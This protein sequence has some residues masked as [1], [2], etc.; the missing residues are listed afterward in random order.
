NRWVE[1]T[2]ADS[3]RGGDHHREREPVR[4]R[5]ADQP[6]AARTRDCDRAHT[7][8]HQR[9]RPNELSNQRLGH[10]ARPPRHDHRAVHECPALVRKGN[11][12]QAVSL[13]LCG[14]PWESHRQAA[15]RMAGHTTWWRWPPW[16]G[17]T[18][19]CWR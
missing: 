15:A 4:Q 11:T 10:A 16:C 12:D 3:G 5:H 9:E 7:H 13:I 6:G 19:A 17:K 14:W 1:M 8:E 2:A 18:T